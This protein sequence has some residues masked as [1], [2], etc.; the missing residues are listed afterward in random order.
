MVKEFSTLEGYDGWFGSTLKKLPLWGDEDYETNF[1]WPTE[2]A[3]TLMD[4]NI[5]IT[6]LE[7]SSSRKDTSNL[8]SVKLNYSDG[9][10]AFFENINHSGNGM[11][12]ERFNY[13]TFNF[14]GS[15]SMSAVSAVSA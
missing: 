11:P 13:R 8:A 2:E 7:F 6:S 14:D 9:E 1:E 15:D 10:T 4:P 5:S 12:W 3:W